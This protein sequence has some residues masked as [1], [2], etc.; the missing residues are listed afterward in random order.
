MCATGAV[1]RQFEMLSV[2]GPTVNLLSCLCALG[3][4]GAGLCPTAIGLVNE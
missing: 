3:S 1:T 4:T 2:S